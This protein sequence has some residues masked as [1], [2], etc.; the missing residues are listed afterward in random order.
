MEDFL[1][2]VL[3]FPTVI[4]TTGLGIVLVYWLTVILGALD[5]DV[6]GVDGD[7]D[8]DVDVGADGVGDVADGADVGDAGDAG[9]GGD[10][11]GEGEGSTSG[12][13]AIMTVLRLRHAPLTVTLTVV[14]LAGWVGAYVGAR[15]LLPLLPV[16]AWLGA[17]L[18]A[19]LAFVLALPVASLLTRPLGPLFVV[20]QGRSKQS[21]VGTT[22]TIRTGRVDARDGQAIIDED[23]T[24]LLVR[25]RCDDEGA[26]KRGDAALIIGYHAEADVY[27]V[28]PLR[29]VLP[30]SDG[31]PSDS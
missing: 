2:T 31:H 8:W 29:A 19:L 20:H 21:Y 9:D 18:V 14:L 3:S 17:L 28:E 16:P 26:L 4:Y 15:I 22:C 7:L 10:A 24:S 11:G 5:I 23:G 25:V 30:Q 27:D 6:F 12:L 13:A 1:Q